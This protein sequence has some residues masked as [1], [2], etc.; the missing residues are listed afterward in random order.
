MAKAM[1]SEF[2]AF[3]AG[4]SPAGAACDAAITAKQDESA[5]AT[6]AYM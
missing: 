1:T 6:S 2:R 5:R 4:E 3:G